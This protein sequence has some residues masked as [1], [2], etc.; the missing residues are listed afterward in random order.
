[1]YKFLLTYRQMGAGDPSLG[2]NSIKDVIQGQR[3]GDA[4]KVI[5]ASGI[6]PW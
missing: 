6:Q 1:M 4:G 5:H 2:G 3:D